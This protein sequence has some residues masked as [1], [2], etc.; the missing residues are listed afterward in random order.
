MFLKKF[1]HRLLT[2]GHAVEATACK[3]RIIDDLHLTDGKL[4]CRLT[5]GLER[6]RITDENPPTLKKNHS[7]VHATGKCRKSDNTAVGFLVEM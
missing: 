3:C 5:D 2:D 7:V 6:C 4:I 1:R